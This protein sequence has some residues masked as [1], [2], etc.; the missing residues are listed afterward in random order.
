MSN[1]SSVI[2][3]WVLASRPKTLFAAIS[4]VLTGSALAFADEVF[5]FIPALV[6]LI[7]SILIQVATNFVNDLYDFLKGTDNEKRVGPER[8]LASG[9]ISP[10]K[11]KKAIIFTF[12]LAFILGLFLVYKAGWPILIVGIISIISGYAY[13]AGPL[14]LAYNG[15]GDIFVFVFFG[16]VATVGTY[17]VQAVELTNTAFMV[18]IPSGALITNILVVNNYRDAETDKLSN[19]KT[20]AVIF[21]KAFTRIQ[22]VVLILISYFIPFLLYMEH[23]F[24]MSILLPFATFPMAIKLVKMIY[25]LQGSSLNK[26]LELSAKFSFIFS[27]L[28]SIGIIL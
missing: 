21:G 16:I 17:F 23:D 28:F 2:K 15:L 27:V 25:F 24:N 10:D 11:M 6:A 14:P 3:S 12:G 20:L 1:N 5:S 8:A 4:P 9:L 26:T 7:C 22:Y 19:K 18:A 13:T